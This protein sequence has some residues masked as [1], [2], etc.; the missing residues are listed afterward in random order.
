M[1]G[2]VVV[3]D[4]G[5]PLLVWEN[6]YYPTYYVP[7]A[8]VVDGALV[9]TGETAHSPS[10]GDAAVYTVVAGGREAAG[11]ARI[12]PDSPLPELRDAV[13]F[14]WEAMDHWFEEDEEVYVHPRDPYTRVD[15]LRSSRE[16]RVDVAGVTVARSSRPTLL[17]ETG[18]PVRTYLPKT[19]V[20]MDLLVPSGTVTRCP[21]KGTAEY[22]AVVVD[23]ERYPDLAWS[24]PFPAAE[25]AKIAGLVAFYDEKVDTVVDGEPRERPRSPFS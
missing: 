25:S 10:R 2:G 23:G 12:H 4:T 3:A 9:P 15:I 18:L 5:R 20:R 14:E 21:Y 22:W 24:Y 7:A 6:P 8:D 19:D 13:A 11:A 16:V 1:L 17:F